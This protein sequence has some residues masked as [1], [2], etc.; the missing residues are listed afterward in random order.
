[1][2]ISGNL[3]VDA[4]EM[5]VV[6]IAL[7]SIGRDLGLASPSMWWILAGFPAG[8][9]A[10][11]PFSTRVAA[12]YG[13][14]RVYLVAMAGFAGASLAAGVAHTGPSLIAT[15][16][17]K[18]CC[19]ALTTPTGL[20]ILTTAWPD[21]G[22]R[23]RA[24]A[25]YSGF[26]A[27]GSSSGL[28]LSGALTEIS[29]RWTL[30]FPVPLVL[31]LLQQAL[32]VLPPDPVGRGTPD[33]PVPRAV[34]RNGPLLR[35]AL[36][37]MSLNGSFLGLLLLVDTRFQLQ[38]GWSPWRTAL[39]CLP[40]CLPLALCTLLGLNLSRIPPRRR[41]LL[42]AL[43]ALA[44]QVLHLILPVPFAVRVPLATLLVGIAFVAAFAALN[45]QAFSTIP[46]V[47]RPKAAP[48]FQTAV[49]LSSVA[50]IIA[51]APLLAGGS[52]PRRTALLTTSVAAAGAAIA[53]L[54]PVAGRA[55]SPAPSR[56]AR[57][58]E[59]SSKDVP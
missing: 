16:I 28:L 9:A 50:M 25:V 19:A 17:V 37:A 2:V 12:R 53:L 14:R 5:F 36:V 35:S 13:R 55:P 39:L 42:G 45:E 52:G 32:R 7:P 26:G 58:P 41:I 6:L 54:G 33:R 11:L 47:D 59:P 43:A 20:A 44:G 51:V 15:Q 46:P 56:A 24:L 57:L 48:L 21:E 22:A 30:L 27:A 1:M 40:A 18:G 10:L 4:L 3:L 38:S 8:F 31:L 34:L 49:Q 29:W 23:K